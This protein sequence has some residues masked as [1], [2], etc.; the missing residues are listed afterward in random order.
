MAA[1]RAR[2][3]RM[4]GVE[5]RRA[6]AADLEYLA[7]LGSDP[8]VEPFLVPGSGTF[9]ELEALLHQ[10]QADGDPAGLFVIQTAVGEGVG[11]EPVGGEAVGGLA[12]EGEA[13]GGLTRDGEAPGGLTRDGEALGGLTRD[14]E[15]LGGLTREGEALGGLTREG[16]ALGGLA[17]TLV[18][19]HSRICQLNRLMV[20][21]AG[22]GRGVAAQAVR[23]ACRR[24]LVEH[25][26]HRVQVETY[27]DNLTAQRLFERVGFT[28][29]GAR[30][31]AYWR[32]EQWLDGV[33]YGMLAEEVG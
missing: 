2:G 19:R 9:E 3:R 30:R 29:E 17:L 27:G 26:F 28:Y 24:V 25:D 5:L 11:G 32:R 23:L 10:T 21:P 12:R 22:R 1:G 31:R 6:S 13:L 20:A 4:A 18:S 8:A 16:E 7:E 14:G 33:L 15:A